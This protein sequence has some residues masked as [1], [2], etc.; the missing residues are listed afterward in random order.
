MLLGW[1]LLILYI[2][3]TLCRLL[4]YSY[5]N[6]LLGF[7]TAS[8][9]VLALWGGLR[10]D[11]VAICYVSALAIL[12]HIL[13]LRQRM[14]AGYQRLVAWVYFVPN[15]IALIFNLGDTVYFRFIM[16]RTSSSVFHEFANENPL[17]FVRFIWDYWG[18]TL[19]TLGLI[20]LWVWLY[21]RVRP[22]AE[23]SK[24]SPMRYYLLHGA[25]LV[26]CVV[27]FV[28]GIRGHGFGDARPMN[29]SYAM[30][31]VD[32]PQQ[33]I[34]VQN[35][36]FSIIRTLGKRALEPVHYHDAEALERIYPVVVQADPSA[37]HYGAFA[38]RNVVVIIWE[39]LAR[40]WVGALNED[41]PDYPTY[42]PFL[43]SLIAHAYTFE[44]AYAGAPQSIDALPAIM[45][46]IPKPRISFAS[47]PYSSCRLNA[48]PE[49]LRGRGYTTAF[50]HNATNGSMYFDS[51][52]RS[53]GFEHYYGRS[54]YGDDR[55]FDGEWGIFDGPFLQYFARE[56]D[57]MPQPFLATEFTTSSHH[58]FVVPKALEDR[59]PHGAH[60]HHR[61]IRY[62]DDSLREFF[63]T[64]RGSSW[65]DDTLF[66]IVADHAVAGIRPEYQTSE[67]MFRIPIILYDP[68]GE[69][70]GREAETTVQQ[71]DIMPTLL[72]LLGID[73]PM[74]TWGRNMFDPTQPHLAMN[75]VGEVY[76]LIQGDY[77]LQ[78]DGTVVKALYNRRLDPSLKHD[79]Q[80]QHPEV[81]EHMLPLLQAYVQQLYDRILSNSLYYGA[82]GA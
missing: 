18:I 51:F 2:L 1:R 47:S 30:T 50:F 59:Y 29:L 9:L 37:P 43:D 62:T 76:Q 11:T 5:N 74:V 49:I 73:T 21:G 22:R 66:L 26:G 25:A 53:I 52:S 12:L 19:I 7:E 64:V 71:T 58:P 36:P 27:L 45:A 23:P 75:M 14:T 67:G 65:F 13:P 42:T 6:D 33:M 34:L 20:A 10:F 56:L 3:Y 8:D 55:D 4:F 79:L 57:R 68:R 17:Q 80:A 63:A 46:G 15:T 16:R 31:Y 48:L 81:V 70:V 32:R 77:L 44:L 60:P 24:L 41:I 28:M 61:V 40:E 78:Y 54:E 39:S 35:T 72:A 69:L 82:P 38:G